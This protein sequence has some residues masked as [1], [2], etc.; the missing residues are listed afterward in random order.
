MDKEPKKSKN[1]SM[2]KDKNDS[3]KKYTILNKGMSTTYNK[4]NP[5]KSK[6]KSIKK[7]YK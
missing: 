7:K 6:S 5:L 3:K 2:H 1:V 4:L